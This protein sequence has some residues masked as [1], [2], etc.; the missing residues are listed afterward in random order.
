MA[1]VS[2]LRKSFKMAALFWMEWWGQ[3]YSLREL[4]HTHTICNEGGQ[5]MLF[6]GSCQWHTDLSAW[7]L[8]LH[9]SVTHTTTL[10]RIR[11]RA[12]VCLR[13]QEL[14]LCKTSLFCARMQFFLFPPMRICMVMEMSLNMRLK[15]HPCDQSTALA[16]PHCEVWPIQCT[17]CVL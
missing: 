16:V 9:S 3:Q 10:H 8:H 11:A 14:Y 7:T 1:L 4:E 15:P 5:C 17:I 2:P 13:L 6:P 12:S